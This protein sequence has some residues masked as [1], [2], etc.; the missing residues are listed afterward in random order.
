MAPAGA[1]SS[2]TVESLSKP[3]LSALHDAA[4]GLLSGGHLDAVEPVFRAL[5]E[6]T[7]FD[8]RAAIG[9]ARIA[10]QRGDLQSA[11]AAWRNCLDRFPSDAKPFWYLELA[12]VERQL[13]NLTSAEACL[14]KC[15]E[16]FPTFAPAAANLASL[17]AF[18]AR[19]AAEREDWAAALDFWTRCL[20]GQPAAPEPE[21]LAGRATALFRLR[22]ADEAL[23]AWQD[24]IERYP[25]HIGAYADMASA[26][27][28]LGRWEVAERCWST[29]IERFPER[30]GPEWSARRT[31]CLFHIGPD[32]SLDADIAELDLRFPNSPLGRQLAIRLANRRNMG[33]RRLATLV[34][35]A[36]GR[37]PT[38]RELLAQQVRVLLAHERMD[39]AEVVVKRLEADKADHHALISR[40]RLAADLEGEEAIMESVDHAV[41]GRSLPVLQALEIGEF[42][43]ALGS[44][45]S[46]QRA[47]GLFDDVE[48]RFPG[49]VAVVCA[50]SRA[51]IRLRQDQAALDLIESVPQDYQSQDMM[52][53]RAW[54]RACLGDVDG[55]RRMW[56]NILAR[57]RFPAVHRAEPTLELVFGSLDTMRRD[58]VTVLV[59]VRDELT[60]L[61][62]FLRHYRQLGVHKF[63]VID[64]MSV[65]GSEAYLRA[66]P[67]VMLYRTADNFQD[68]SCGVRWINALIERHGDGGWCL[69]ADA[70]EAFIYPGWES[71][72]LQRLTEYLD[73]EGAEAVAAF[74]LDVYPA[75]LSDP[76]GEPAKH[77][78]CRYYDGNYD[79]IGHVRP[80][81][82]RP[83]GGVRFRLF[84][85][86]EYLQ[87]VPLIKSGR[88]I[89]LDSHDSTAL[90]FASLTGALLHYK[91]LDLR[92]KRDRSP[93]TK[94]GNP[95]R[96]D[97]GL[98]TM[99]R[100]ERYA[101]QLA[102]ID[103]VD[104]RV[105]GVSQVLTDS[106]TLAN[107]GL[108]HAPA[109]FLR[110]MGR[111]NSSASATPG[112]I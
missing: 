20:D 78:D 67:D 40:W 79:W 32:Q 108:M 4:S 92:T 55:A 98:E 34:E 31:L 43:L 110:W 54:S 3:T 56:Q 33:L 26:A 76:E 69:L 94:G 18:Q 28:E 35:D 46:M 60:Q 101:S 30:A 104:L 107:Q 96:A 57:Y 6:R 77:A 5:L 66:Q 65:D 47:L 7:N 102:A 16:F 36:L 51:L 63:I 41:N 70:D 82:R 87:K 85:A 22:R 91:M 45:W 13:G 81:Y 97:G 109:E 15:A 21:W 72:P 105:P 42:L 73:Q 27:D 52:E 37:F 84:R 74:M 2:S 89:H 61:P 17:L 106:L 80:P 14:R 103:G 93:A 23:N 53:L 49:R 95:F 38:D 24:L 44:A 1:I 75:R 58:G 12:R 62:E 86:K 68:A 88:G 50:R 11:P 8:V 83:L 99:R 64:N 39:D 90:R 48:E 112:R 10:S 25:A 19:R 59:S 71:I 111:E 29:L 100:Y 9:L